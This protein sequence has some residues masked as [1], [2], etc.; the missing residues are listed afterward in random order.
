MIRG[1]AGYEREV[2]RQALTFAVLAEHLV[3]VG[4][5]EAV[6]A[7]HALYEV[8]HGRALGVEVAAVGTGG[9]RGEE[10]RDE[11]GARH[12]QEFDHVASSFLCVW[13]DMRIPKP[14]IRVTMEVP[15]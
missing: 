2:G 15:P 12:R 3:D 10:Q 5:L 14:A 1:V 4:G 6:H 7:L 9:R 13:M 8:A 11:R